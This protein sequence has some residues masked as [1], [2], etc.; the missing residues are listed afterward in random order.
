MAT[1][2]ESQRANRI[3]PVEEHV[4]A[5]QHHDVEATLQTVGA[6]PH[7]RIS[8][9]AIDSRDAVAAF[10]QGMVEGFPDLDIEVTQ[11]FVTDEAII[12]EVILRGTHN[13]TWAGIPPS[14]RRMEVPACSV[15]TFDGDEKIAEER[16]YLDVSVI[17]RQIGA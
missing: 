5:E 13:G 1:I 12:L 15:Y 4:L 14:G 10:Y 8:D 16:A 17:M 6:G 11:R 2:S 9:A 7:F 3:A